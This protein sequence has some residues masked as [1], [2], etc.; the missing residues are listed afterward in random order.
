MATNHRS[1]DKSGDGII[2]DGSGD[3][4]FD[5]EY[6]AIVFR[7]FKNEVLDGVVSSVEEDAI[8]VNV[9]PLECAIARL[10]LNEIIG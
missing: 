10:V 8:H 7:P 9:G 4:L 3:V 6:S 1:I 2:K 5:V